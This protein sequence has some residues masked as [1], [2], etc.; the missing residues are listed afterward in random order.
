MAQTGQM[1]SNRIESSGLPPCQ[2]PGVQATDCSYATDASTD[3]RVNGESVDYAASVHVL[4]EI[5][6]KFD[7]SRS[8]IKSS[9][10][11]VN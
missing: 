1:R 3:R 8:L 11:V 2:L 10:S 9:R 6:G 7:D 5:N 4:V